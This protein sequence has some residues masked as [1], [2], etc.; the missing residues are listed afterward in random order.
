MPASELQPLTSPSSNSAEVEETAWE[1]PPPPTELLTEDE[2][3]TSPPLP[4]KPVKKAPARRHRKK[5][6]E[7][8]P[9]Y[10]KVCTIHIKAHPYHQHLCSISTCVH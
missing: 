6:I 1:F 9:I 7:P 5:Q 4:P 8:D 10:A 2:T 3:P